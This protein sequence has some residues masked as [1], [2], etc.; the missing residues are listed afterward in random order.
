MSTLSPVNPQGRATPPSAKD[1]DGLR[2]L[3]QLLQTAVR[4]KASDV[5]LKVGIHPYLRVDGVLRALRE[6]PVLA[7]PD[8]EALIPIVF[9]EG[10]RKQLS[11]NYQVD[12]SLGLKNIG[13][14]RVNAYYQ[15]GSA[16]MA[17]RVIETQIPKPEALGL[18]AAVKEFTRFERGLVIL[19]GATGCGKST[20]LASL[21]NEMNF[22]YAKNVITIEDPIEYLFSDQRSII[23][24]RE[25]GADAKSFPDAMVSALRED[26]DVIFL[27]E[28]RDTDSIDTTLTA[29]ETGHLVFT[30]LHAPSAADTIARIISSFAP[31]A[32]AT[33]RT[34]L[35]QNLRAVVAQR[36]VSRADGK[37]RVVAC[38]VMTVG[39]RVRELILDPLR[40]KEISDLVKSGAIVE[41]MLSFD[42]H[43]FEL[44]RK[45]DITDE[46]A[47]QYATSPTDLK[48]KLDG[49]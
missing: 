45:G 17:L 36:L 7:V 41:G 19:T 2:F 30:T 21:I 31:D 43:L 4:W 12:G 6:F 8:M 39:P 29:A 40:A 10:H 3:T 38:E 20:T 15:R 22:N 46:T 32:Q 11:M 34:K 26:P 13:R 48:L 16:A 37:G 27:G 5:H 18:P 42:K 1:G 23:S 25:I 35:A 9:D 14:V 47:L 44:C 49:F 33:I 24:Q 28:M